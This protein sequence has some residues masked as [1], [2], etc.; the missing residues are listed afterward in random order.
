MTETVDIDRWVQMAEA[1]IA[2]RAYYTAR[3]YLENAMRHH[4]DD[5][6]VLALFG[7]VLAMGFRNYVEGIRHI[8]RAIQIEEYQPRWHVLAAE[9]H[10]RWHN[11]RAA[12]DALNRALTWDPQYG[13]AWELRQK[14]GIRKR[15]VLPFLPRSHPINVWLGKIRHR[16]CNA[17]K[18][19]G[20]AR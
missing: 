3:A 16:L 7:Y 17:R 9:V 18:T 6:R 14:M 20:S 5:P 11:R 13:P 12:L 4:A 2:S 8:S 1:A 10:L 19:S 15:P